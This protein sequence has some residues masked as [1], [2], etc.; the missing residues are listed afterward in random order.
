M[1]QIIM[2]DQEPGRYNTVNAVMKAESLKA[3][4]ERGRRDFSHS[5]LQYLCLQKAR[6]ALVG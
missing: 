4:Y 2:N 5:H 3:A 6:L 1:T